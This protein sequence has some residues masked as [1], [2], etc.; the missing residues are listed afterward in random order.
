MNCPS[1]NKTLSAPDNA[2]GKKA[3]CPTCGTVMIVPE[4]VHDAEEFG[5][6][7]PEPAPSESN[8]PDEML[9]A[10]SSPSPF[11]APAPG[12]E[13]ARRPC[14]MCGE[15]IIATAAKCRFCGA[16]FDSRLR[17]TSMHRGQSYQGFAITSMVLGI[18]GLIGCW[19]GPV[20]GIVAI[21]FGVVANNGMKKSNNFE[22]KG[23]ATAGVVMGIISTVLWTLFIILYF[24]GLAAGAGRHHF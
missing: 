24:I 7:G 9:G 14:P 2:A 17:G 12:Q 23:M 8:P 13:P 19:C 6:T 3:K 20:L 18:L 10:A 1:C 21:I 4:V 15:Q 5:T 11:S 16:V 22:G